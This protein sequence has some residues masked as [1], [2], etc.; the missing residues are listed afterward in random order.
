LLLQGQDFEKL[1]KKYSQDISTN[2]KGGDLGYIIPESMGDAALRS[3]TRTM[4][5]SSMSKPVKGFNGFYIL[6]KGEKRDVPVP[7]LEKV[8]DR[9]WQT[10]YR[11][12]RHEIQKKVDQRFSDQSPKYQ[13]R[14]DD[15]AMQKIK[16]KAGGKKNTPDYKQLDFDKL[17]PSDY[18]LDLATYKNGSI[19]VEELFEDR[20]KAPTDWRDFKI[21]LTEISQ[22]HIFSQHGREL[23]IFNNQQITKQVAEARESL[24]KNL[25]Y[26]REVKDKAKVLLD[27]LKENS[28]QKMSKS[29]LQKKR[30]EL[31][32]ELKEGYDNLM[33][34]K[35]N[36]KF[37]KKYFDQAL[38]EAEVKKEEQNKNREKRDQK[39]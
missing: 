27:S 25:L 32:R 6:Y 24:S 17:S 11:T 20:K 16:K 31:E 34:E 36:F 4:K 13:Y 29:D 37:V 35:Y 2:K 12:R 18:D 19:K 23:G 33:K 38:D 39:G 3:I 28:D 22:Q 9:I 5:E 1:A 30:F 8:R 26:Q 21:R 10:L 7:S 15:R 14:I